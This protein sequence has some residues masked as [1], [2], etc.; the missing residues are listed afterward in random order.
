MNWPHF[1]LGYWAGV[2]TIVI[3]LMLRSKPAGISA[4]HYLGRRLGK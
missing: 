4:R 2:A 3:Y 1:F